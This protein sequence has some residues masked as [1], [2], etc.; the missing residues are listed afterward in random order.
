[1]YWWTPVGFL[2][3]ALVISLVLT[4]FSYNLSASSTATTFP[5]GP[6]S[7]QFVGGSVSGIPILEDCG[8][9][10]NNGTLWSYK[11]QTSTHDLLVSVMSSSQIPTVIVA[12]QSSVPLSSSASGVF[13]FG[14][15]QSNNNLMNT[16]YERWFS[17]HPSATNFTFGIALNSPNQNSTDAGVLHWTGLDQSAYTGDIAWV[18]STSSTSSSSPSSWFVEMDA[19]A[20]SSFDSPVT[21]GPCTTIV[22]LVYPNIS[23]PQNLARQ[24]R[25]YFSLHSREQLIS[26]IFKTLASPGLSF[27]LRRIW[28]I[29]RCHVQRKPISTSL[30]ADRPSR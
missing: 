12:N 20:F 5:N 11:N 14:V 1:M 4:T 21:G 25:E 19:L 7:V 26:T 8:L 6:A 23:L 16:V 17:S 18:N 9:L 10:E 13:G 24:I 29:G 30:S 2:I 15:N 22:D 27:S 28:S 3:S